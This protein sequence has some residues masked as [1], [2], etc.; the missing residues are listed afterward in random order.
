MA[1][2]AHGHL[3]DLLKQ[4]PQAEQ[5][6]RR[7]GIVLAA[8]AWNREDFT[9]HEELARNAQRDRAPRIFL[10]FAL[11]PQ[12][13]AVA[14]EQNRVVIPRFASLLNFMET[15]AVEKRIQGIGET[16]FDL[17]NP[18]FRN[19]EAIQDDLFKVHLELALT[20]QLPLVLHVRKAMHKVF[21]YKQILKRLPGVIFHAYSG[22]LGEGEALLRQG[23]NAYFSFGT[24]LV[25]G[26][27]E[28]IR[29]CA[30]L[31]LNRVLLETDTPY[32]PLR[33]FAF[34]RWQDLPVILQVVSRL[35]RDFGHSCEDTLESLI[36]A[37]FYRAYGGLG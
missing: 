30:G 12:L 21:A 14:A 11:H 1:T 37:N 26:R 2:D 31:P 16:G 13:P 22:T 17:Y 27:K 29:S 36:D 19:T 35:R 6:R 7:L 33:G 18:A 34:S 3:S 8:S 15:L 32:Q 24:S 20:R 25:G 23:I 5:E 4:A 10:C 9:C 28:T